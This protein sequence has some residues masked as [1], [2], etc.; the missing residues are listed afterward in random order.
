MSFSVSER[1]L[2][3]EPAW[4]RGVLEGDGATRGPSD[5][6]PQRRSETPVSGEATPEEARRWR[7]AYLIDPPTEPAA[8]VF[9]RVDQMLDLGHPYIASI[10]RVAL[11]LGIDVRTLADTYFD[12]RFLRRRFDHD[13][14]GEGS[15]AALPTRVGGSY[16]R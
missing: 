12:H 10:E 2:T 1:V 8:R 4:R 9:R 15:R 6:G 16:E 5:L 7:E 14:K 3:V 11:E 13:H